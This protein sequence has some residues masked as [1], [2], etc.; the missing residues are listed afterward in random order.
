MPAAN[1][2][3]TGMAAS[4][5]SAPEDLA[6]G[7]SL[8]ADRVREIVLV[9]AFEEA[10][11]EGKLLP[12]Q[13]RRRATREAQ[14]RGAEE[15]LEMLSRRATALCRSIHEKYAGLEL[16][17]R[18]AP[19][20]RLFH[21]LVFV[22]ALA[23]GLTLNALGPDRRINVLSLPLLAVV[24]WNLVVYVALVVSLFRRGGGRREPKGAGPFAWLVAPR[25]AWRRLTSG[26]EHEKLLGSALRGF[27]A[28]WWSAGA[29]L[30]RA[31]IAAVFHAGSAL[32]AL[33]TVLG[34]YVR[35]LALQYH[36]TWESTFLEPPQVQALV[37]FV[38]AP[39]DALLGLGTELPAEGADAPAA[40][41]IHLYAVLALLVVIVPRAL[42]ALVQTLRASRFE[43][44]LP[45]EVGKDS[46][47]LRLLAAERGEGARARV[48]TYSYSLTKSASESLRAFLLDV[49]GNRA[50]VNAAETL[51]Y[52]AEWGEVGQV[53][54]Q[55]SCLVLVFNAAQSPE[56]EVHGHFLEGARAAQEKEDGS[57]LVLVDESRY[58]ERL[59]DDED[60][61]RRASERRRA[62]E[63]LCR[64]A[65]FRSVSLPLDSNV[66]DEDLEAARE[67]LVAAGAVS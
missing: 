48:L 40:P 10:D 49:L 29:P 55:T 15:G 27:A 50:Q 6:S 64:E 28:S 18:L 30:H 56:Q 5:S 44:A 13:A 20:A 51:E 8:P 22:A 37:S 39:A 61:E 2:T 38:L 32:V 33:G 58:A 53:P 3:L 34:M 4:R 35:G 7:R 57:V 24:A 67:V 60:G 36:L 43:R 9:R 21:P 63:R 65:G 66:R 59:G 62:W 11:P 19:R 16:L 14:D 54:E 26:F 52:G 46:Y 25:R 42:L 12:L 45:L 23:F 41:W 47:F 1:T 17:D 31:R